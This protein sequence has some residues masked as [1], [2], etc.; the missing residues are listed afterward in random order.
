MQHIQ[1]S[2]KIFHRCFNKNKDGTNKLT[3]KGKECFRPTNC[4]FWKR[5][6]DVPNGVRTRSQEKQQKKVKM[7]D[8]DKYFQNIWNIQRWLQASNSEMEILNENDE[9]Y[10]IKD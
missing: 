3:E 1:E 10:V 9:F 5:P 2:E 7:V 8:F 4:L 6:C